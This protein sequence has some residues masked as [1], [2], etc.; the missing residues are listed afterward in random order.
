MGKTLVLSS[1]I[2]PELES[3]CDRVGFLETGRMVAQGT[4]A[5][6]GQGLERPTTLRVR[7][8]G[9]LDQAQALIEKVDGVL[10]VKRERDSGGS[11]L[12]VFPDVA[13]LADDRVLRSLV[14]SQL[15]VELYMVES[16]DLEDLF[17]RVTRGEV[18]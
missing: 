7:V 11:F 8:R 18:S 16:F 14:D 3:L 15:G 9:E 12:R 1:H 4:L 10:E 5:E 17:M 2:L 6:I 13:C